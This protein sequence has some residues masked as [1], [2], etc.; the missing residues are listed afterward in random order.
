MRGGDISYAAIQFSANPE[1]FESLNVG[2]VLFDHET[3]EIA[4]QVTK[5]FSRVSKV[6]GKVNKTFLKIAL[7]D[8]VSRIRSEM[9]TGNGEKLDLFRKS[10]VNNLLLTPFRPV[11]AESIHDAQQFLFQELVG[12]HT[13]KK[14]ATRVARKLK[15]GL[16]E[17][18]ILKNF[19]Q[20]PDPVT[21][22]RYN[23]VIRPDLGISN[24]HYQLIEAVRFDDAESGFS[25]AGAHALA[26]RALA[27]NNMSSRLVVVGDFGEQPNGFYQAVKEDLEAADTKLFRMD[28]LQSFAREMI[29]N[30]LN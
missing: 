18:S 7:D 25:A 29:P 9:V 17:L 11:S 5:D 26:G 3:K 27:S 24:M 2:V 10:R 13:P 1:K 23:Y 19:D 16:N 4:A 30:R 20:S 21:L 8:F 28:D 12:S 22:P 14:R 6:F 15:D